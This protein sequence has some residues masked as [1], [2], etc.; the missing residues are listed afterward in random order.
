MS[1]VDD[2]DISAGREQGASA[3]QVVTNHPNGGPAAQATEF[4]LGG[5]WL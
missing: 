5:Q 2:Q 3:F 4:V 1:D